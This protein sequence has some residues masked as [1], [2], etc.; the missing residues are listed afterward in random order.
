MK[1]NTGSAAHLAD[2]DWGWG[3]V[4]ETTP[5]VGGAWARSPARR[6]W[7]GRDRV[8]LGRESGEKRGRRKEKMREKE[9]EGEKRKRKGRVGEGKK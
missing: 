7:G 9:K 6:V 8:R 4:M 1:A 2:S 3:A 5:I